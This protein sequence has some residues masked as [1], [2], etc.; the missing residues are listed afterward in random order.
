MATLRPAPGDEDKPRPAGALWQPTPFVPWHQ[1]FFNE[2]GIYQV[3]VVVPADQRI[4]C[5]GTIIADTLRRDGRRE[6][7]LRA[8]GVRDFAFLCSAEY[9]EYTRVL[10]PCPGTPHPIRIHILAL[11]R[12]QY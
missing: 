12:H 7:D 2:A 8:E 5:T 6:L 10:E 9:K 11:P 4:A 1:P 3:H